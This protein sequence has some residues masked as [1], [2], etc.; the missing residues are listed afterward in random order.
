MKFAGEHFSDGL[1]NHDSKYFFYSLMAVFCAS[2][3][4][5]YFL[6]LDQIPTIVIAL[7]ITLAIFWQFRLHGSWKTDTV[8][9]ANNRN[10][11]TYEN[12]GSIKAQDAT[13]FLLQIYLWCGLSMKK[14]NRILTSHLAKLPMQFFKRIRISSGLM[15]KSIPWK[16]FYMD[17]TG[18][19]FNNLIQQMVMLN[20]MDE[21]HRIMILTNPNFR[22]LNELFLIDY[23]DNENT[24]DKIAEYHSMGRPL[25]VFANG[26]SVE[27]IQTISQETDMAIIPV[28]Y[29]FEDSSLFISIGSPIMNGNEI[30]TYLQVESNR[31]SRL[32][33]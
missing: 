20:F 8:D 9:I 13:T 15:E 12:K 27:E 6:N 31:M 22:G 28:K 23:Y 7:G 33:E 2:Y 3:C 29:L 18:S 24:I 30:E 14:N 32:R 5:L 10:I 16:I 17:D 4:G 26:L 21:S 19:E 11:T 25:T 1:A